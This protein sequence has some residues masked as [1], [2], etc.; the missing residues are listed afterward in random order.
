MLLP[1]QEP[2]VWILLSTS[3]EQDPQHLDERLARLCFALAPLCSREVAAI[4]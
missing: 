2:S 1:K 4:T 3:Q